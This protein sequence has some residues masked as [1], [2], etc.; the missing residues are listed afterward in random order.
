MQLAR[1]RFEEVG[2][3]RSMR[4]KLK[5]MLM[6]RRLEGRYAKRDLLE[7]YLN[8]V[9]FGL[10]AFGI[11]AAA[12]TYFGK[13]AAALDVGEAA[14][15]VGLLKGP[16]RYNP[17]RH[18]ERARR[19]RDVVLGQMR[20]HGRLGPADY[21]RA[22]R[23]PIRL[24]VRRPAR[25]GPL[26]PHFAEHVRTVVAAWA[27]RHGY[28]LHVD[29]L[30][31][32]TT[33]DVRLQRSAQAAVHEQT[34]GLQ[35][36]AGYEWSRPNGVFLSKSFAP[37][38]R[39]TRTSTPFRYFWETRPDV[40]LAH[41]RRTSAYGRLVRAG[42]APDSAL[43]RLQ[44][45]PTFMDSLRTAASR[46]EAGLVAVEPFTGRVRAWVGGRDFQRDQYDKVAMARRQPG[47]TFKP[48][49]YAAALEAG[50]APDGPVRDT[51]P[52]VRPLGHADVADAL[53][54]RDALAYSANPAALHLI[55]EVGPRAVAGL[56]RRMGIGSPLRAVPSLAL[57]TSEVTL[58]EMT[59]A[60][61]A[62]AAGGIY[63]TPVVV[64][65]I[66]N[67]RGEVLWT[68]RPK[69]RR[70][71]SPYTAYATLDLMRSV[72]GYGTGVDVRE[73]LGPGLDLA[74]KTGTSQGAA[75]GWF[76]VAH[77]QLVVGVWTGF[78][79]RR[80]AFRSEHW[81]RGSRT[82]LPIAGAFLRRVQAG[83]APLR[84]VR[85]PTPPGYAA[86]VRQTG[87]ADSAAF[88]EVIARDAFAQGLRRP[89]VQAPRPPDAEQALRQAL[90]DS[91]RLL[92]R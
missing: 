39:A 82:A 32:Y 29:G 48:F 36:V 83:E 53:T 12:Q 10:G 88:D 68:S 71:L 47:S 70:A 30:R 22:V 4:R 19:R 77:P 8:T 7:M 62:F 76:L 63:R 41:V 66:E 28:D 89:D 52:D 87:R 42:M 81:G 72:V 3:E 54:L 80:L 55:A 51:L 26:A 14:T 17:V 13:T 64:T 27:E 44:A 34:E 46:L 79:D 50:W 91:S 74:G 85:F 15:L 25:I 18:E 11:E 78:G 16:T 92:F 58:L 1:N 56:A 84:P 60:Y 65:R 40:A 37:Y 24:D 31:I 57:G 45:N 2:R 67:R 6:A 20:R 43:A 9:D 59:A 49:V 86:D 61:G 5:E 21:A 38:Q 90:D 35:A 73:G 23:E 75:D 33:L 69:A